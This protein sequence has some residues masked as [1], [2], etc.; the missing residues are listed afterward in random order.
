M[1]PGSRQWGYVD[2]TG[3]LAIAARFEQAGRFCDGMAAVKTAT[4]GG[5]RWGYINKSGEFVISPRFLDAASF[6][7]GLAPVLVPVPETGRATAAGAAGGSDSGAAWGFIDASGGLAIQTAFQQA[8]PFSEGLAAARSGEKWGYI[9]RR[10]NWVMAPAFDEA[11]PF[12]QGLAAIGMRNGGGL[13]FGYVTP[14]GR[15][16]VAPR[17]GIVAASCFSEGLASL[18]VARTWYE[19][20][21]PL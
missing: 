4:A 14:S 16:A 17:A 18:T 7:G 15:Y 19:R 1:L 3:R 11:G 2:K 12:C 20:L 21:S 13:G 10:G 5:S 9:D 8:L 6:A